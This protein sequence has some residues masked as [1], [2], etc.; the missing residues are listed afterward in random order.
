MMRIMFLPFLSI[1]EICKLA[2][3][4]KES[5]VFVD[6]NRYIVETDKYGVVLNCKGPLDKCECFLS[7]IVDI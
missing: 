7:R 2:Q 4:S 6:H 5:N 3:L 1:T